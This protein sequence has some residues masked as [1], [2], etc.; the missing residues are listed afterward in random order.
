MKVIYFKFSFFFLLFYLLFC[1]L[2]TIQ[3]SSFSTS[4]RNS[5]RGLTYELG[6]PA[7]CDKKDFVR[8]R[9]CLQRDFTINGLIL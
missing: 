6:K 9:N 3:V 8:W 7:G 1:F 5:G 2:S 4:A